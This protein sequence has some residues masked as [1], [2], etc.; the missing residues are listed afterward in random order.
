MNSKLSWPATRSLKRQIPNRSETSLKLPSSKTR[1][2]GLL[3]G[4]CGLV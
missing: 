1:L 3:T 4:Q 2:N